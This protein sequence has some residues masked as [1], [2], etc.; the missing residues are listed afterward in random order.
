[1]LEKVQAADP[2]VF[3]KMGAASPT[4]PDASPDA[5]QALLTPSPGGRIVYFRID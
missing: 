1:M 2:D 3:K 5:L 4:D